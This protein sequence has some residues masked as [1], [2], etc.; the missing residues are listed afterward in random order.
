MLFPARTGDEKEGKYEKFKR[1]KLLL[2]GGK[3]KSLKEGN[4][5]SASPGNLPI[6]IFLKT[7][8]SW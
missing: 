2:K 1:R 6:Q 3:S 4:L 5:K 7:M 8:L